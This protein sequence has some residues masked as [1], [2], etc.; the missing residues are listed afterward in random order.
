M[1]DPQLRVAAVDYYDAGTLVSNSDPDAPLAC[2]TK[3]FVPF[4]GSQWLLGLPLQSRPE[5][6]S[7]LARQVLQQRLQLLI[8]LDRTPLA[9]LAESSLGPCDV[10]NTF[11][12]CLSVT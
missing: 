5:L 3:G 2:C 12:M 10:R 1:V 7:N 8:R 9:R 11:A 6:T 4:F